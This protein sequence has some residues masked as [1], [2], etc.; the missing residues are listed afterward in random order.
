MPARFR[1]FAATAAVLGWFALGLQLLLSIQLT[2]AN[3]QGALAGVW[4]YLG[5]YTVL[6]NILVAMVLTAG[7]L[8]PRGAVTRFFGRPDVASMAAMSIVVVGIIYNLL[9]RQLWHPEGWQLFADVTL[10]DVMPIAFLLYWWFAVPKTALHWRQ[11]PA[12]QSYPIAYF[13]YALARGA[14]NG[15]YPY[16]FLDVA[17]EGYLQVVI[18]AVMVLLFFITVAL[19]LVG[20]GRWQA[21]RAA[22]PATQPI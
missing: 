20:L 19:V 21:R 10:H 14:V 12:W 6:T 17:H 15:W 9:L 2:R 3:G 7:A 8:G 18:N 22:Q 1:L 5:F 11:I 13:A 16:P 4:S